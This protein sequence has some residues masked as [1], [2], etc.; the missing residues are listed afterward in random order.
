MNN[1][2]ILMKLDD[3]VMSICKK[4]INSLRSKYAHCIVT[5]DLNSEKAMLLAAFK[6]GPD[7]VNQVA[8]KKI[9]P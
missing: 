3:Q 2:D 4:N 1:C 8:R 6:N 5:L 7:N 9:H